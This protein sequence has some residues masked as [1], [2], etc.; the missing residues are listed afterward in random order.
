MENNSFKISLV[1]LVMLLSVLVAANSCTESFYNVE[2]EREKSEAIIRTKVSMDISLAGSVFEVVDEHA[3][4]LNE[5]GARIDLIQGQD[6]SYSGFSDISTAYNRDFFTYDP[7]LGKL[8]FKGET[9]RWNI[10]YYQDF[11]YIWVYPS[12]ALPCLYILGNG[13]VSASSWVPEVGSV[14]SGFY[15]YN[16]PYVGVAPRISETAYQSTLYLSDDNE[17]RDVRLEIYSDNGWSKNGL[18]LTP[19]SLC[20]P[21]AS[22]FTVLQAGTETCNLYITSSFVAGYYKFI[23]FP[24]EESPK[25]YIEKIDES[26]YN[27]PVLDGKLVFHSYSSYVSEDSQLFIYDFATDNL[28]NISENW[29]NV[30][31]AMNGH[32]S[33]D[34]QSIVFMGISSEDSWDIFEYDLLDLQPVNLTTSSVNTRDEDPKYSNDGTKVIFKRNGNLA[35]LNL[36]DMT[37]DVL[38]NNGTDTEYGM[39]YYSTDDTK[40]LFGFRNTSGDGLGVWDFN[41]SSASILYDKVSI[42][43]YYP[44][45]IDD[46]SFYFA[47]NYSSSNLCDQVYKGFWSGEEAIPLAFNIPT[48][49]YSD[50]CY[51]SPSWTIFSS[52]A[53]SSLSGSY[54][55]YVGN[56]KS[57]VTYSLSYYNNGINSV[58]NEL[59]ADYY[60]E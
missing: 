8:T 25:V 19:Q 11:N 54:D 1:R 15:N 21:E 53:Q 12:D 29:T 4:I 50:P 49:D 46:D 2:V 51:V 48:S 37:I 35:V 18:L 31:H 22:M 17:W 26:D 5:W 38:T 57:G 23:I 40:A 43:E 41:S 34:G 55:L 13:K 36:S 24:S 39:P 52:T 45:T 56:N 60:A 3:G 20:G 44:I 9:G 47:S 14:Q 33:P 58:L 10:R 7:V 32:F 59:G 27:V 6:V 16:V 28:V 30:S 42:S